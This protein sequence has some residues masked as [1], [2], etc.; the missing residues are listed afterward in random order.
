[1]EWKFDRYCRFGDH[2]RG[3]AS[4]VLAVFLLSLSDALVK[5]AGDRLGLAQIVF[6]RSAFAVVL[7]PGAIVL[8]RGAGHPRLGLKRPLWVWARS[9]CLTA[10]WGCYY[11]A[12][13]SM[14]LALAAACYYTAP[15][16]MALLSRVFLGERIGVF[17]WIA[18]LSALVGVM[19]VVDPWAASL[20]AVIVLP[21]AAA[22]FYAAA[23][24]IT[25]S[26]CKEEDAAA[27]AFTLNIALALAGAAGITGLAVFGPAN[28]DRFVLAVWPSL[29]LR[30]WLLVGLLG[31]LL[32]VIAIAVAQAYRL[33]PSPVVGVFDNAYLIFAAVW[34]VLF[35][36]DSLSLQEGAGMAMIA[37]GAAIMVRRPPV[38]VVISP[39]RRPAAGRRPEPRSSARYSRARSDATSPPDDGTSR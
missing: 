5:S 29:L 19:L 32:S 18:I 10:M 13:P 4:I 35:F 23:A 22:F 26:R 39:M 36:G 27:M 7:I 34:S 33:T 12:L 30:D 9:L 8:V 20:S 25:W 24:I 6:L 37:V 15:V 14:S 21:L 38:A 3:I 11:A 17:G 1:M 2:A 31:V 16:W 28:G